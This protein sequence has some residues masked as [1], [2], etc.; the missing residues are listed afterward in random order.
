MSH[1]RPLVSLC[2]PVRNGMPYVVEAIEAVFTQTYRNIEIIIQDCVS[3]DGTVEALRGLSVPYDM[4]LELVSEQD[5]GIADAYNRAF[6]RSRGDYDANLDADNLYLPNHIET[7]VNYLLANPHVAGVA[8]S[9]QIVDATGTRLYDWM[10]PE[11]DF[12]GVLCQERSVPSGSTIRNRLV[13]GNDS[14]YLVDDRWRHCCDHEYWLRLAIKNFRVDSLPNVTYSTRLSD[15]S[16]SCDLSRYPEF[17][18][19][20]ILAL[21]HVLEASGKSAVDGQVRALGRAG[22]FMWAAE[23]TWGLGGTYTEALN[24]TQEAMNNYPTYPRISAFFDRLAQETGRDPRADLVASVEVI[25]MLV[26]SMAQT[27]ANS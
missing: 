4:R 7:G 1:S 15:K 18:R 2:M 14:Y 21:D 22:I 27:Q 20:K 26:R 25:P 10:A 6:R 16:G 9:Q 24:F 12:F 8:L 5:G 11:L 13:L 3:T 19:E 23:L 17:C